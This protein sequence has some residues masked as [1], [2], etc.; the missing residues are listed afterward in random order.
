[1]PRAGAR[2]TSRNA[3]RT[4]TSASQHPTGG[5]R[6]AVLLVAAMSL[7]PMI[8]VSAQTLP[9]LGHLQATAMVAEFSK[10]G[11]VLLPAAG[12]YGIWHGPGHRYLYARSLDGAPEVA[13]K[14]T[15]PLVDNGAPFSLIVTSRGF[16]VSG[17]IRQEEGD[18][19]KTV[20]LRFDRRGRPTD[21]FSFGSRGYNLH[22][23]AGAELPDGRLAIL[24][25]GV[26]SPAGKLE[27]G[28]TLFDENLRPLRDLVPA[29]EIPRSQ[30]NIITRQLRSAVRWLGE[31]IWV[32]DAITG[33]VILLTANGELRRT[34]RVGLEQDNETILGWAP[35][36]DGVHVLLTFGMERPLLA[37][38]ATSAPPCWQQRLVTLAWDGREVASHHLRS[39]RLPHPSCTEELALWMF[40]DT[41][42]SQVVW[43]RGDLWRGQW[44]HSQAPT[45]TASP[46]P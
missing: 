20:V 25:K 36:T 21:I 1:M 33:R 26:R 7:I 10:E 27:V 8:R 40:P 46:L 38:E 31:Q 16:L 29:E 34:L 23:V 3:Y 9:T 37:A 19:L 22:V 24:W 39:D 45:A 17:Y 11:G 42:G 30:P 41:D 13:L 4:K 28:I 44:V 6:R 35:A 43:H 32:V 12:W 2:V 5:G 15:P 18:R 14:V